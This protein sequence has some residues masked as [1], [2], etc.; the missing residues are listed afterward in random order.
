MKR[1]LLR[2]VLNWGFST[3]RHG[4]RVMEWL[5]NYISAAQ[6]E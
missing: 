4:R 2:F 1:G 5:L 6:E 3:L